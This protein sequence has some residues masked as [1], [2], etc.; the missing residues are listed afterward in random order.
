MQALARDVAAM[1]REPGMIFVIFAFSDIGGRVAKL[2]V[3]LHIATL[4]MIG[5]ADSAVTL[6]CTR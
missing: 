4:R 6:P 5:D 2:L 1:P 3:A